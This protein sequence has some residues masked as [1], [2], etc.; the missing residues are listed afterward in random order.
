MK[1]YWLGINDLRLDLF[2]KIS[3]LVKRRTLAHEF[4][5]RGWIDVNGA[6]G[7]PGKDVGPGDKIILHL[8]SRSKEIEILHIPQG[9]VSANDA[10]TLYR[11]ISDTPMME[12]R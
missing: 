1:I 4:C 10:N 6:K 3:R 8:G 2:L 9:N 11:V 7:K 12:G 5:Q